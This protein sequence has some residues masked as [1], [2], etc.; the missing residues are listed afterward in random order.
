MNQPNNSLIEPNPENSSTP[1]EVQEILI[2]DASVQQLDVLL[3]GLREGVKV[4]LITP[5]IDATQVLADALCEEGLDTLHVL[6]HGAPGE[7]VLGGQRIDSEALLSVQEKMSSNTSKNSNQTIP[8]FDPS[9]LQICLW[10]CQTGAGT[11][12][13]NFMNAL[14][15]VTQSTVFL[16]HLGL[17]RLSYC[18][19]AAAAA[20]A[21]AA[22][23]L[24][25][26][27]A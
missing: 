18:L 20:A 4:N 24:V 2:A 21:A 6:G 9:N 25:I 5:D 1:I 7:V 13:N 10:S 16:C 14:S 17:L 15:K 22:V 26:L 27:F 12:G 3:A 8:S 23:A 11:K 19:H